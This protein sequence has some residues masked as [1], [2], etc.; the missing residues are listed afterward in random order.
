MTPLLWIILSTFM[1]S[2]IAW[3]GCLSLFIKES[4]IDKILLLLVAL[5]AGGLMGGAFLHLLPEAISEVGS[6]PS[7]ILSLF[8]YLLAGFCTFLVMEQFIEWYHEH[9]NLHCKKPVSYLVLFSD[10]VHNFIDGLV[11]SGSFIVGIDLGLATTLAITLHEI[12]QELGD[13]AILVY[14]GFKKRNALLFNYASA[15]TSIL[16]GIIGYYLSAIVSN[17]AIF[18]VSF[19]AGSFIYIAASDLIPE[20]KHSIGLGRNL[21][22][23]FTFLL[24][25]LLMYLL[26][27]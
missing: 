13:F 16:G 17:L 4:V 9:Y 2:L 1:I 15:V 23:F 26:K 18:L 8:S 25:I 12:P 7:S 21:T 20:I 3:I 19:S 24:G 6:D 22:H 14:G 10:L 27:G 11:V 5:S